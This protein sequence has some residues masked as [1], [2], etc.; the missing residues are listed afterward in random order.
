MGDPSH[1]EIVVPIWD[2]N[3]LNAPS[4]KNASLPAWATQ[5]VGD[6]VGFNPE[7]VRLF[8]LVMQPMAD[9][10]REKG[11]INRTY[12]FLTDETRWPCY[13]PGGNNFTVNAYVKF[14]RLYKSL[15]ASIPIQQD[16]TPAL[17]GPAW[18]A[19]EPLVDAWVWQGGQITGFDGVIPGIEGRVRSALV[20]IAAARKE[21]KQAYMYNNE[22]AIIDLPAHRVRTFP[23]QIWR[24]NYAYNI[25]RHAGL[26]GSLSW[27][28]L[29]SYFGSDPYL[30]ANVLCADPMGHSAHPIPR[31]PPPPPNPTPCKRERAA[32]EWFEL[33]PPSNGDSCSTP[34]TNSIRW[35]LLRQGLEDVEYL[36]MLDRLAGE[37]DAT[38]NCGYEE[39]VLLGQDAQLMSGVD[40]AGVADVAN[41]GVDVE[42]I[43]APPSVCCTALATA[44]AALDAVD[45]V[46][47]G[48][49]PN[50]SIQQTPVENV[51]AYEPYTL[52]PAVLHQVMDAVARAIET[53][54]QQC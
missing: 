38:H 9:H 54:Q 48:I 29:N 7:F 12:A 14:A 36:A 18:K 23:W 30:N 42:G 34:P 8:T 52:D 39:A 47:W 41:A 26:Q 3:T 31:T 25:S 2:N 50:F 11:W 5:Q 16:L 44:K 45:R 33:Y 22:L 43:D 40:A 53:V 28:T 15:D 20:S 46:T 4:K 24:T 35:E 21:G 17:N 32:G 1:V 37:A 27:Y 49:T 51:T 6:A 10:L 13:Q 19:V